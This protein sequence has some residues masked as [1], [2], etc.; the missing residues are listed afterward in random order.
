MTTARAVQGTKDFGPQGMSFQEIVCRMSITRRRF[1]QLGM[2]AACCLSTESLLAQGLST[3]SAK[4]LPRSAPSGRPFHA[5][6]V[7]VA[8]DAGLRAPVIYGDGEETKYILET[9]GCGCA[10][11]DYDNDGWLD[12]FLL[13][14]TRL[15]GAPEGA[16]NRLYKNNR[17]GT[18]TDVTAK[19]GL[20]RSGWASAVTVGDYDNDGFDDLFLTYYGQ[21][22]L[23]HNNGDGTFTDVTE[24][25]GLLGNRTQW[26]SGCAWVDYNRDGLLDLFVARYLELDLE[27]VPKR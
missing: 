16:T 20:T 8:K 10:F 22:V 12:V 24:R 3:H 19:A 25:A 5:H 27:T 4:P 6:F 11:I 7:D 14:G 13:S 17:D 21:N 9:T 18:F 15:E 26:G 2:G 23:Y 1:T